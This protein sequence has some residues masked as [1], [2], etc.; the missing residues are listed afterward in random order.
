AL[1]AL[2]LVDRSRVAALHARA[3]ELSAAVGAAPTDS[4]VVPLHVGNPFAA[5]AARDA[6]RDDGVLVGCFRP[7]SVPAGQSCLRL[8]ARADLSSDDVDRAG[9]VVRAAMKE[10]A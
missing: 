1:A 4:A 5:V 6:C 2:R 7:P 9:E 10:H 8:T 3:G